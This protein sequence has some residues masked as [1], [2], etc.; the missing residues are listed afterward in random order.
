MALVRL[1][2]P[3]RGETRSDTETVPFGPLNAVLYASFALE[4]LPLRLINLPWGVSLLCLARK[5][6]P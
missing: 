1:L 4:R 6:G 3:D 2:R 5:P